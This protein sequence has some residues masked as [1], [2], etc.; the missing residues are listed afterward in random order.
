MSEATPLDELQWSSPEWIQAFGLNFY[1]VLEYFSQSPFFDRTS[2]NQ[3]LRMQFQFTEKLINLPQTHPIFVQNL[4]KMTG[5]EFVVVINNEPN[6][7]IIRKQQR[8]SPNKVRIL[9][10]YYVI[11]SNI[12]MS[13][14]LFS[15]LNSRLLNCI[16][17]F[18][19]SFGILNDL[20]NFNPSTGH[21]YV[22]DDILNNIAE[23]ENKLS[24][25]SNKSSTL[26]TDEEEAQTNAPNNSSS[27][28]N[29]NS[30]TPSAASASMRR[31]DTTNIMSTPALTPTS[32][33][34]P[35]T[36]TTGGVGTGFGNSGNAN[37]ANTAVLNRQPPLVIFDRLLHIT[38]RETKVGN[39]GNGTGSAGVDSN[40]SG[41]TATAGTTDKPAGE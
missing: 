25:L 9:S 35:A 23:L 31:R 15:I 27:S 19:K 10:D 14:N 8:Q 4:Q 40:V 41:G 20:N 11:N 21:Q 3:V 36:G 32:L 22:V 2:N 1:N 6:F 17:N 26:A 16:C 5:I 13:P 33:N 34:T 37:T 29:V 18:K 30:S 24:A 12:Y 38:M 28:N 39:T 7:Y